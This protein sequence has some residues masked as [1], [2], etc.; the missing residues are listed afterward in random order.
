M[1]DFLTR[2]VERTSGVSHMLQPRLPSRFE[3]HALMD[4][5][6][7]LPP[8]P[9]ENPVY[10]ESSESVTAFAP[11]TNREQPRAI[12]SAQDAMPHER[13][14]SA[15]ATLKNGASARKKRMTEDIVS[16]AAGTD[17][18]E[19]RIDSPLRVSAPP[20]QGADGISE[21]GAYNLRRD[22]QTREA[23][24]ALSGTRIIRPAVTLRPTATTAETEH[25]HG[26]TAN[27]PLR[28]GNPSFIPRRSGLTGNTAFPAAGES[29]PEPPAI[30]VTIGRIDVRAIMQPAASPPK[31]K[32]T[33]TSSVS[34][35]DY[36]KQRNEAK[37]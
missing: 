9:E 24:L 14:A 27:T 29:A 13:P 28:E 36:L 33:A 22:S 8:F 34:L 20:G 11:L 15:T 3:N 32:A 23:S 21:Q 18:G 4:R 31:R 19:H 10:K 26:A 5:P 16:A 35:N 2:L 30:Q 1:A 25:R 6:S 17:S 7:A 37:R 12:P